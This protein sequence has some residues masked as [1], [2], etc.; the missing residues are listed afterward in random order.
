M[1][2]KKELLVSALLFVQDDP[3][4][5]T[6]ICAQVAARFHALADYHRVPVTDHYVNSRLRK[7]FKQWPGFSGS[8]DYPIGDDVD[9]AEVKYNSYADMWGTDYEFADEYQRKRRDL[10]E[11]LIGHFSGE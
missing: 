5:Y 10:L 9:D 8:E 3:I 6:G 1:M 4:R 2:T 11:W 7:A